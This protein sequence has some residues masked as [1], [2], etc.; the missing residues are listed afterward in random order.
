M[1][2]LGA[3]FSSFLVRDV[4][5]RRHGDSEEGVAVTLGYRSCHTENTFFS[6]CSGFHVSSCSPYIFLFGHSSGTVE[7]VC[8][9]SHSDIYMHL[10]SVRRSE[11]LDM[12]S[13][14]PSFETRRKNFKLLAALLPPFFFNLIHNKIDLFDSKMES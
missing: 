13:S 8:F 14:N 7:A 6:C 10:P 11:Y 4:K 2:F 5:K 9:C 3:L 1:S 12:Q